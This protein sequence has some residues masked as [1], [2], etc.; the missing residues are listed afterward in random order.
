MTPKYDSKCL[1][2][3]YDKCVVYT[4]SDNTT[5][6]ISSGSSYADVMKQMVDSLHSLHSDDIDIS[7]L[8]NSPEEKTTIKGAIGAVIDKLSSLSADSIKIDDSFSGLF[9]S[10]DGVKLQG[11]NINYSVASNA[12]TSNLTLDLS[13][14]TGADI[15]GYKLADI[16]TKITG[17]PKNGRSVIIDTDKPVISTTVGYDRYPLKVETKIRY[18][19]PNGTVDLAHSNVIDSPVSSDFIYPM[20]VQDFTSSVSRSLA[21]MVTVLAKELRTVTLKMNEL[22]N[23]TITGGESI[24]YP[25]NNISSVLNTHSALHS[26]TEKRLAALENVAVKDVTGTSGDGTQTQP[27]SESI[28][29]ITSAISEI[30]KDIIGL[31]TKTSTL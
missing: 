24:N 18:N 21:E 8:S 9:S 12:Q 10:G 7:K 17:T 25:S 11:R 22:N 4:G 5:L 15:S 3:H 31:K 20:E 16:N 14:A 19:T 28:F 13:H 2:P 1:S 26:A 29:A 23:M 30:K 27:L 6:G